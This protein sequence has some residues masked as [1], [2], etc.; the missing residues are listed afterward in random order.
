MKTKDN[1]NQTNIFSGE[2]APTS[3]AIA[4]ARG[5]PPRMTIRELQE[6]LPWGAHNY[7]DRFKA[8]DAPH[9]DY[10]HAY[11]HVMKALGKLAPALDDADHI[12]NV[13]G[14]FQAHPPAARY[15]ADIIIC[16]VRM[17][18]T[19]PDGPIDVEKALDDRIMEIEAKSAARAAKVTVR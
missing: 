8:N 5:E 2:I 11:L 1:K 13:V 19:C 16:A 4:A 14:A 15:I 12:D 18:S 7:S 10:A 3:A 9:R 17:A 6:N